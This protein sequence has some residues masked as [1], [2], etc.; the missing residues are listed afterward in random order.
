LVWSWGHNTWLWA[1]LGKDVSTNCGVGDKY[2]V[3]G[4]VGKNL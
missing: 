3:T 1:R 2:A 4:R